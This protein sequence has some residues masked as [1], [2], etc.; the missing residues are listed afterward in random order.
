MTA[1]ASSSKGN[2]Y[3][4]SDG[5][6]SLL[7]EC[8]LPIKEIK[9]AL[10]HRLH[11]IDAVLATHEHQDHAKAAKDITQAGIDLYC[12]SGTAEALSL[13]G[14]RLHL[15]KALEQFKI[16][17]WVI[18]PFDTEHD[19]QE[20]LGYLIQNG[21]DKLLFATDTYFVRYRFKGLTVIFIE[22]NYSKETLSPDLH[23]AQRRRLLRSHMSLETL[24]KFLAENDLTLVREIHLIHLSD[25]NS[26]A[27]MFKDVVQGAT[28][29]PTYI[30]EA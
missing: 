14:H 25:G 26:N 23:P 20:P 16:G 6:S 28:G 3:H 10:N 19:A 11:D 24:L 9:E 21:S 5:E 13:T 22:C 2:M 12:S 29:I 1:Y 18:L 27:Q 17:P 8:G 7:L 15:V 30:E 4:L